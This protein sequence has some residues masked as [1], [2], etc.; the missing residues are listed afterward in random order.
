M[1]RPLPPIPPTIPDHELIER[2]GHGGYGEVW[3]AR[4]RSTGTNG[5]A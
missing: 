5:P 3:R 4:N 2:I 1:A